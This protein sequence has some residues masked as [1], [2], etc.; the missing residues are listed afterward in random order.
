MINYNIY[1]AD[2]GFSISIKY[3]ACPIGAPKLVPHEL[4]ANSCLIGAGHS[5]NFDLFGRWIKFQQKRRFGL[6]GIGEKCVF[7]SG[8]GWFWGLKT[9][10]WGW[11]CND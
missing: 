5:F 4:S 1:A 6:S 9:R 11:G 7:L 8:G 10:I 3:A 2:T